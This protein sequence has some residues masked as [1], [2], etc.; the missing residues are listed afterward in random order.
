[1]NGKLLAGLIASI[2]CLPVAVLAQD[3][4]AQTGFAYVTYFECDQAAE[5]RADEIVN[6]IYAPHYDS[7]LEQGDIASW[8][9]LAHYVGGKWRPYSNDC[10]YTQ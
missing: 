3:Q 7:A 2:T 9:W 6:R 8:S 10:G 4:G 1:M 5:A